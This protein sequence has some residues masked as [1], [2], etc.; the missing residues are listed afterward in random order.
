MLR[1]IG[2]VSRKE[3]IRMSTSLGCALP[4]HWESPLS[5]VSRH[6]FSRASDCCPR[7][8]VMACIHMVLERMGYSM[9]GGVICQKR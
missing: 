5:W 6:M 2:Y 9:L 8:P 1:H 7:L 3:G 4:A